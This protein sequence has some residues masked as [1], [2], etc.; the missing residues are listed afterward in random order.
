[1]YSHLISVPVADEMLSCPFMR[2]EGQGSGVTTMSE[3]NQKDASKQNF[4][5]TYLL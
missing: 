3:K 4:I 1:M 5:F 2:R